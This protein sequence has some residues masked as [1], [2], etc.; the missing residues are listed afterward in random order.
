MIVYCYETT[1]IVCLLFWWLIFIKHSSFE[2]KA[3]LLSFL[4]RSSSFPTH[5]SLGPPS[6]SSASFP[7]RSSMHSPALSDSS[8]LPFLFL[9]TT[10]GIFPTYQKLFA[11]N[12]LEEMAASSARK[13]NVAK[14]L[15]LRTLCLSLISTKKRHAR[16]TLNFSFN[17]LESFFVST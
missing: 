5:P 6:S 13:M 3:Y 17:R 4:L 8:F 2:L 9:P 15:N 10:S 12:L 1:C 14:T 7:L 11:S 16:K